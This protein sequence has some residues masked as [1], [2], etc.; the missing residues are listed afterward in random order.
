MPPLLNNLLLFSLTLY[1]LYV[2]FE[3]IRS[4]KWKSL[5]INLLVIVFV[6]VVLSFLTGFPFPKIP[7]GSV[8]PL[9]TILLMYFALLLGIAAN[10]FYFSAVLS[11]PILLKPILISPI[12]MVPL[13]G[14]IQSSSSIDE[15]KLV[16]L[17]LVAFQNGFF[18]K[19]VFEKISKQ[20]SKG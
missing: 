4:K 19:S 9:T 10:Y 12:V 16:S 20:E 14:L 11:L 1:T 8:T 18:W 2:L 6:F 17:L 15:M 3:T 7:F 13:V 5:F